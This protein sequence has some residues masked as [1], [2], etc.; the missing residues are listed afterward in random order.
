MKTN[1]SKSLVFFLAVPS[2]SKQ[3]VSN[4]TTSYILGGI[5]AVLIFGYLIYTLLK[6]EKF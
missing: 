6:P 4:S 5:I 2:Q 1:F 3:V